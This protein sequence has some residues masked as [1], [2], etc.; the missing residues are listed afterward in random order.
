PRPT[1]S[2]RAPATLPPAKAARSDTF[3][4]NNDNDCSGTLR[5][6]RVEFA[7]KEVTPNNELN[8]FTWNAC[9]HNTHGDY[10]QAYQGADDSFEWFGGAMDQKH[11]VGTDGTDDGY[12][13]QM[14]TRNRAQF[15]I[16][17]PAPFFAPSGT[18]NGDKGIEADDNEFDFNAT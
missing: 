9:G 7:G 12:D 3:G 2:T 6:V 18:Q 15:V 10:L 8:S 4:G 14:G 16:L 11:L 5:Y 17:R 13:W 1:S